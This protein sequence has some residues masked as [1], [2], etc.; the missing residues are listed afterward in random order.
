MKTKHQEPKMK[1]QDPDKSSFVLFAETIT[2]KNFSEGAIERGFNRLV[3]KEDY[4]K[5][6]KKQL[7]NSLVEMSRA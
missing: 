4:S 1:Y 2:R 3:D 5:R 6:E 7:L